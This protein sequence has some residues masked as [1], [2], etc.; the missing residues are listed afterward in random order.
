ML[1]NVFLPLSLAF[2]IFS[3]G[4]GLTIADFARV[5]TI[6]K[7][8]FVGAV[9]QIVLLPIVAFVMLM[10]FPLPA[11]LAVGVM[12]LSFC[13]GGVT[14]NIITKIAGGTLALSISLTAV[15]S[16]LSVI[17]VPLL[18]AWA[19]GYFMGADAPDINI[20]TLGLSMFAITAVPVAI[21]VTVRRYVGGFAGR[22]EGLISRIATVLFVVI[23]IG[24]LA[25]NWTV[26][27]ENV[28]I[29][30]PLLI[31]MGII[32]FLVGF[33]AARLMALSE[34]DQTAISIEA[35][36]Q[37]SALGITVGGLI[38]TPVE[39]F[40]TLSLP[41]GVYGILMYVIAIP[42]VLFLLRFRTKAEAGS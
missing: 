16:L 29:L 3:L 2:I 14:S 23:V 17:T 11:E 38:G 12:I 6:P 39:G 20:T 13:P 27:M 18:I 28:A 7:A 15:V 30:G 22:F 37:N 34:G 19:S 5:A 35:G 24:A 36:I 42:M 4:L 26:F 10:I 40:A 21:G 1:V 8:F 9:A 31:L 25:A 33:G 32:L 41:S